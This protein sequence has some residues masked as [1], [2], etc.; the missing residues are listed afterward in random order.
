[1]LRAWRVER[2]P[3]VPA[4]TRAGR[5]AIPV[6]LRRIGRRLFATATVLILT[7]EDADA[8]CAELMALLHPDS[9]QETAS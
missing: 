6:R 3:G 4:L 1:M 2:A 7:A 5:V 9:S 8:L